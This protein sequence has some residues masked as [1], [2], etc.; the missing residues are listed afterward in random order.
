MF[1]SYALGALI[2]VLVLQRQTRIRPVPRFFAPRLPVVVGAIGLFELFDYTT[3]HHHL[4]SADYLWMLGTLVGGAVVLGA[5]R[6]LTMRVWSSNGWVVRQGTT[7]TMVLWAI[8]LA[9]HFFVDEGGGHAGAAGLEQ[10][11]L[12]LYV[13]LTIG[14][15]AYVVHRRAVPLWTELGPNAGGR[16]QFFFGTAP[17]GPGGG[18]GTIFGN[19]GGNPSGAGPGPGGGAQSR[20]AQYGGSD[21]IDVEVVDDDDDDPPELPR[22]H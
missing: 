14:V 6:G 13:A 22:S 5:I 17:G 4:T 21:I 16:L 10:A 9:L 8:S 1:F 7:V 12:L 20:A 18:V 15:Q 3:N 11:S 2:L 19:F